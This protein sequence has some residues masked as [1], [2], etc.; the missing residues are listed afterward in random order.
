[1]DLSRQVTSISEVNKVPLVALMFL[2]MAIVTARAVL[3]QGGIYLF[4]TR[5]AFAL[6]KRVYRIPF[7]LGQFHSEIR[8]T[9]VTIGIDGIFIGSLVHF[10]P[11]AAGSP[12]VWPAFL[13]SATW[14]EIWFY[15]SHRIL[16]TKPFYFIHRQHHVATVVSPFSALSFSL[17]ER[18]ILL[19]GGFGGI[20]TIAHFYPLAPFG[21]LL[22]LLVNYILNLFAH[23]NV[24]VVPPVL[25]RLRIGRVLNAPTYHALHHGRY[26]G[27][28]GLYTP[29]LDWIFDSQF[30]D[31]REVQKRAYGGEGLS[32][33]TQRIRVYSPQPSALGGESQ[34]SYDRD[35]LPS[36]Q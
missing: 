22:Y 36:P 9:A 19:I 6:K 13:L 11:Q 14:F 34:H 18:V 2:L 30:D 25:L 17:I 27:H 32:S 28:Y 15:V 35:A 7:A 4:V 5:S 31:Y 3:F 21:I 26:R 12:N 16:H 29:F 8:A 23:L 20:L 1:M 24:E 10:F 33:I